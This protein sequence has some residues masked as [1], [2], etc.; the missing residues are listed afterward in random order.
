MRVEFEL[1]IRFAKQNDL[2]SVQLCAAV[3]YQPYVPRMGKKPAPMIAD[4]SNLIDCQNLYVLEYSNQ[5]VGYV[6]FHSKSDHMFLENVAVFPIHQG[7]GFG[8]KLI[9]F[10][11]A[12]ANQAGKSAVELY[13]N[14]KMTENFSYYLR[15]GYKET[16]RRNEDGFDRVYFRKCVNLE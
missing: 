11:E 14:E 1:T 4:F 2:A 16:G 7:K 5:I 6:V 8:R 10:V 3:A 15:H 9:E 12:Q 13:T